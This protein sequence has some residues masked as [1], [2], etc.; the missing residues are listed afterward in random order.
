MEQNTISIESGTEEQIRSQQA[1]LRRQVLERRNA[2]SK[3][4][5]ERKD[6]RLLE[7]FLKCNFYQQASRL[8]CYVSYGSEVDTH[9]LIETALAQGKRVYCPRVLAREGPGKMDFYEIQAFGELQKGYRG[10]LEPN[11]TPDRCYK[12]KSE[13]FTQKTLMLIPGTVFDRKRHRI[14]YGGGFYDRFLA[15]CSEN[16]TT[17]S[18]AYEMQLVKQ[19]PTQ[20]FD[21]SPQ[22][23]ITEDGIWQ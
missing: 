21:I 19:I 8:L 13:D 23:L 4:E 17:V 1:Q 14:G 3:E 12:R 9:V 5:R 11:G 2:M 10:I 16:I 20:K 15:A 18:L 22:I 7:K 6:A